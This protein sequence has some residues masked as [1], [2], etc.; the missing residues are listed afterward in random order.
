VV[1]TYQA[2]SGAGL[3]GLQDLENQTKSR[4]EG[5]EPEPGFFPEPSAFNVFSHDSKVDPETGRN[6]EEQKMI[7]ETRKI[8]A[9]QSVRVEPTCI[10]VPVMRAH[11]ESINITLREP[12]S[13]VRIRELLSASPGLRVIDDR[14]KGDFPT[15]LKAS[16]GDDVMVGRIRA[17]RTQRHGG[18]LAH[19]FS[20][21]V[22]G[23]Q[24]RKGAALN[25]VQIA[26]LLNNRA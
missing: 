23:D 11:A 3:P 20:L 1:S 4:L 16:D 7:E 19:G 14:E 5:A 17:D 8:W 9:D 24:I 6:V 15:S 12:A 25:A 13:E 10:R 22:A 26:E 21:F 2:V 18:D